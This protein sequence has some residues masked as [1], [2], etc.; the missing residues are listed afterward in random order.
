LDY[1]SNKPHIDEIYL[2]VQANNDTAIEFY[3]K[4]GFTVLSHLPNYYRDIEGTLDCLL[5]QKLL[6]STAQSSAQ[7]TIKTDPNITPPNTTAANANATGNSTAASASTSAGAAAT[8]A[9]DGKQPQ[10]QQ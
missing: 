1:C 9:A 7:F 10:P 4:S 2:H 3:K 5:L 6:T 8:P